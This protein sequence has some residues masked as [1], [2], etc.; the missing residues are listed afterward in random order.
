MVH[1]VILSD[2]VSVSLP[3]ACGTQITGL[4]PRRGNLAVE[5]IITYRDAHACD[6]ITSRK[7]HGNCCNKYVI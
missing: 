7:L 3:R 6:K 1:K 4:A 5:N 2:V